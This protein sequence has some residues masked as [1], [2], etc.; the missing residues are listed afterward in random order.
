[1]QMA[2][3]NAIL[4][5]ATGLLYIV[6]VGEKDRDRQKNITTAFVAMLAFIVALN[7]VM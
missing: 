3:I 1:M 2:I 5:C 6:V 4:G 7:M